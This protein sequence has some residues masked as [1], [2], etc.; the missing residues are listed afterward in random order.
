M[1]VACDF[2]L[3][4]VEAYVPSRHYESAAGSRFQ[5]YKR[6]IQLGP[7]NSL[8]Q[9]LI[10]GPFLPLGEGIQLVFLFR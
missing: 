5:Q 2:I 1:I 10:T 8:K 6:Q 4:I 7:K 9:S 3:T